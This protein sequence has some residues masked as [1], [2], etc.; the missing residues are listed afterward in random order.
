MTKLGLKTVNCLLQT[1]A[2]FVKCSKFHYTS[3]NQI[4]NMST[5]IRQLYFDE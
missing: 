4:R 2:N 3:S 5:T 1:I